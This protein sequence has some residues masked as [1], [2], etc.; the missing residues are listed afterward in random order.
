MKNSRSKCN[1][2]GLTSQKEKGNEI[3]SQLHT[4]KV[5]PNFLF[6]NKCKEVKKSRLRKLF[7]SISE[8]LWTFFV[9]AFSASA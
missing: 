5:K 8:E 3:V 4:T 7:S 6:S 1:S 2:L 9:V